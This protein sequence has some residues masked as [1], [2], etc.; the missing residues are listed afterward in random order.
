ML[1]A[2]PRHDSGGQRSLSGRERGSVA[3][4]ATVAGVPAAPATRKVVG[5][6]VASS[7]SRCAA[8]AILL[9]LPCLTNASGGLADLAALTGQPDAQPARLAGQ[10][11]DRATTPHEH[12]IAARERL[13]VFD[14][15]HFG[16][17]WRQLVEHTAAHADTGVEPTAAP[18]HDRRR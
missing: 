2:S 12:R 15:A 3:A 6:D 13:E 10:L 8:E 4:T 14:L 17:E 11:L 1:I 5:A 7:R 9:E 16:R 18:G